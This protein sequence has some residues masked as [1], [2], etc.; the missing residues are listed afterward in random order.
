ML[1]YYDYFPQLVVIVRTYYF[2]D[3]I[4]WINEERNV[5]IDSL[6]NRVNKEFILRGEYNE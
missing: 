6:N 5:M 4:S 3:I 2:I 1:L